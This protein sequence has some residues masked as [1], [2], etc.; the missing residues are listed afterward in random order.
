LLTGA[1]AVALS[2]AVST[3]QA[4][5]QAAPPTWT[6]WGEGAAFWTGGGSFNIPGLLGSGFTSFKPPVG[7]EGAVGFDYRWPG[8]PWHFVFDFRYGK[9]RTRS[10]NA[11]SFFQTLTSPFSVLQTTATSSASTEHETHL[12]ADF[13]IGRDLGVG[14]DNPELEFGIRI[15]DLYATAH[16]AASSQRTFYTPTAFGGHPTTV[17]QLGSGD[18]S[19]RFFGVGPRLAIVGGIPI[20]GEWSFDYGAGIAA[21]IGRRELDAS[22]SAG[23]T[24]SDRA[25]A[26]VFNADGWL[27][28]TVRFAPQFKFSSGIRGDFYN[29]ALTTYDISGALKNIDRFYWGPFVRLTGTF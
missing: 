6:V 9:T 22:T 14:A 29:N 17:A 15:A 18:W 1:S 21:L 26:V 8:Q 7:A 2:V 5:P 19:S 28:F 20:V 10:V 12:V 16:M 11:S 13:M 4:A 23:F 24:A 3:G 25:T 27:A